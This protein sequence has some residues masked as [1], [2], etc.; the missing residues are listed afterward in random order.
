MDLRR[1]PVVVVTGFDA[2]AVD[3]VASSA[4]T[5]GTVVVHHDLVEL[6]LGVITRTIR[7]ADAD[8]VVHRRITRIDLDHGCVSCALREDLLPLLRALHRRDSVERIVLQL[9]P[10]IEPEPL[11]WAIDA[12]VVADVP[13]AVDGPAGRDVRI[14]AVVGCIDAATWLTDATGDTT[15]SEVGLIRAAGGGPD[16]TDTDERTVAQLAVG[17]VDFA[18][19]VVVHGVAEDGWQSAVLM[20]VLTRLAP[21]A[22][23]LLA[24]PE[25]PISATLVG[26]LLAA[27]PENS[28]RGEMTGAHDPLLRGQPPLDS[29]CGVRLVEFYSDRPM[30]P[31]RLH[32]AI[33]CLLDGVVC[34]RGRLWLATQP[35]EALWIESAG[36]GL[37][38]ATGGP[39]LA[40]MSDDEVSDAEAERVSMA[41]LRWHPEFGDRDTSIVVLAVRAEPA[42]IQDTLR[43]ACL[44]DA[45]MAAGQAGWMQFDDPFGSF[46]R[47]PCIDGEVVA[48]DADAASAIH[49]D[50]Q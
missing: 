29:D 46:H 10:L 6:S 42:F 14:E 5:P 33:D 35:D 50:L 13:G 44:T 12:V 7:T 47:D 39:W 22:P 17:H 8:G 25:R 9:D 37:R 43:R 20:A 1:I 19:A 41:A 24:I 36:G 30:H 11:C 15:L 18:D 31:G 48:D 23:M 4:Q 3:A 34:S 2:V 26:N 38:V 28:R 49:P 32:E 21:T 16:V 45:E 27:V 40:A